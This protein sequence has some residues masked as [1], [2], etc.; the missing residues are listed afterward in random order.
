MLDYKDY[1]DK[2]KAP[3]SLKLPSVSDPTFTKSWRSES[4]MCLLPTGKVK[5]NSGTEQGS[6]EPK[7]A[8]MSGGRRKRG[9][10]DDA[11]E[12]EREMSDRSASG[13]SR[14]DSED[15]DGVVGFEEDRQHL[16]QQRLEGASA[17]C[18]CP[19]YKKKVQ[20]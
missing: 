5:A 4:E 7:A 10:R 13:T 11:A 3:H 16:I 1:K 17:A 12:E 15:D 9:R 2:V 20:L 14:S 6:P 18:A 8:T 19:Q